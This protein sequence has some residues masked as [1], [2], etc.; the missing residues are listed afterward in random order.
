[1]GSH[2]VHSPPLTL[3]ADVSANL[4]NKVPKAAAQKVMQSLAGELAMSFLSRR[5]L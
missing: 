1:M 5:E 4:K 3:A 2:T